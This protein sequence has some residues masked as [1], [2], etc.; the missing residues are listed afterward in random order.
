MITIFKSKC[1]QAQL[2]RL[3]GRPLV[4]MKLISTLLTS[5]SNCLYFCVSGEFTN[6][7]A[8]RVSYSRYRLLNLVR[9]LYVYY[10]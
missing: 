8:Q 6:V 4:V 10:I 9:K 3:C 2:L 5:E 1:V 7:F